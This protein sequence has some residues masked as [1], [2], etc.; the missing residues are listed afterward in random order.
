MNSLSLKFIKIECLIKILLQR[1]P[2]SPIKIPVPNIRIINC[3]FNN[4]GTAIGGDNLT[5]IYVDNLEMVNTKKFI[6]TN[7]LSYSRFNNIKIIKGE[8]NM[9]TDIANLITAKKVTGIKMNNVKI[10]SDNPVGL[11]NSDEVEHV[12]IEN[13]DYNIIKPSYIDE[14]I[15]LLNE[16]KTKNIDLISDL[17]KLKK[18][19]SLISQVSTKLK[20]FISYC[21][22]SETIQ[23]IIQIGLKI[24]LETI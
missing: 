15:E 5:G 8:N 21:D 24:G 4:C 22:N 14:I 17:E 13:L 2:R 20:T 3:K 10:K 6:D 23:A 11:I 1:L 18:D 19:Q 16:E 9:N 12:V 7:N